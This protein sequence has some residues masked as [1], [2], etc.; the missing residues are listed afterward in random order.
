MAKPDLDQM[1][2]EYFTLPIQKKWPHYNEMAK[3]YGWLEAMA[4]VKRAR[5]IRKLMGL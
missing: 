5:E 2:A 1:A 4:A 3:F